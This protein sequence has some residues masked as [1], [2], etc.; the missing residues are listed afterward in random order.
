MNL[1]VIEMPEQVAR[2]AFLSY[3]RSVRDRHSAE[4]AEV[5]RAYRQ[6][7]KGNRLIRL[8]ETILAGG[9]I[10]FEFRTHA[11]RGSKRVP[12]DHTVTVPRLAVTRAHR[13]GCW[14]LGIGENGQVVLQGARELGYT[15]RKDRMTIG[16]FEPGK[17][18]SVWTPRVRAMA[19]LIPPPLRPAGNLERYHL[20]WEAEWGLDPQPPVDPALLKYVGGDLYAV[21][22]VW[23]L[24][25]VERAV[26]AGREIE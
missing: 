18:D 9:T 7:A 25:E 22:A 14:T 4:D 10:D 16:G 23:D 6:L 19:P 2:E 12:I 15:N 3:R 21:V 13:T 1:P 20:L 17:S 5:M 11:W 24:T 26:L 8:S